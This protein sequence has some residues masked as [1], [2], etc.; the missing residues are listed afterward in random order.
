MP[1]HE[2]AHVDPHHRRFVI[3][4]DLGECLAD[5]GFANTGRSQEQE[6]TDWLVGVLKPATAAAYGVGHCGDR[7]VLPDDALVQTLFHH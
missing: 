4:H 7:G 5:F 3:E 1:F 6:R 2:F